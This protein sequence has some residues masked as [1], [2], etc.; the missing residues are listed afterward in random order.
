MVIKRINP[1]S[2]GKVMGTLGVLLGL[3]IGG[4]ISLFALVVG[5]TAAA[6]SDEPGGA[7]M[8]M[9]FGVGAIIVAPIFYG[10]LMF[11]GG[12]LQAA[13]YNLAAGWIGGI[14]IDVA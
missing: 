4:L 5:S 10:C 9:L 1:V 3:V 2:A 11:I 8:G 7:M 13:L 14:E 12:L 6:V